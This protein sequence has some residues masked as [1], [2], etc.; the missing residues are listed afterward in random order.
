[1]SLKQL[2]RE[3]DASPAMAS[4]HPFFSRFS[5]E[6][7][8]EQIA[9]FAAQW[10]LAARNHKRAFP[11]LVAIT[12]DDETR[13]ELIEILRDEYGNGEPDK[14]HA[15]LL[16]KFMI[17]GAGLSADQIDSLEMI[18]EVAEFGE[19]TLKV[20]RDGDPIVAYGY[21]YALERIAASI[22]PAFF[23]GL[24]GNGFSPDSL[25]YFQYHSR[26]EEE[27]VHA[28]EAGF[29]RYD[30]E[31]DGEKLRQGAELGAAALAKMWDGFDRHVF[32]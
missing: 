10:Y 3:L 14:V 25:E 6:K 17:E 21:H 31:G 22:H 12:E 1:M 29:L 5:G 32:H 18:P 9:R 8:S 27:H 28:A 15:R 13:R 20:W 11:F 23:E 19:T 7:T 30:A 4:H 2:E 16:R 24:K 26:A